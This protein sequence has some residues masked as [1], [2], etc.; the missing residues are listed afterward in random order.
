V[1]LVERLE[2]IYPMFLG[3]A[4]AFG[5]CSFVWGVEGAQDAAFLTNVGWVGC[6]FW[7]RHLRQKVGLT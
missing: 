5:F 6:W 1:S 3:A 7:S 4:L 2:A